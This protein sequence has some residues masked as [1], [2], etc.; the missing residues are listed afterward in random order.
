MVALCTLAQ[1]SWICTQPN[2]SDVLSMYTCTVNWFCAQLIFRYLTSIR[3]LNICSNIMRLQRQR[4][5]KD[6]GGWSDLDT[7]ATLEVHTAHWLHT[8]FNLSTACQHQIKYNLS[9]SEEPSKCLCYLFF[10][11]NFNFQTIFYI[12]V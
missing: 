8:L 3:F 5:H 6:S 1:S 4:L 11:C 12:L 2:L 7:K 10:V 9:S